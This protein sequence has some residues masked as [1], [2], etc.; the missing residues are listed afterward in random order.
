MKLGREHV[1]GVR[2][3]VERVRSAISRVA[4]SV[5]MSSAGVPSAVGDAAQRHRERADED[6]VYTRTTSTAVSELV[7]T[8]VPRPL[9]STTITVARH[10][11]AA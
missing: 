8:T 5:R 2:R 3:L 1:V 6:T 7:A 10:P 11:A 4:S 9:L